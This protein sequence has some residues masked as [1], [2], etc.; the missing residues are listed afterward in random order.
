[1]TGTARRLL[2][3]VLMLAIVL[4]GAAQAAETINKNV[5]VLASYG[6]GRPGVE[7]FVRPYVE[8][9]VAGGVRQ[10]TLSVEY[11]NLNRNA[12]PEF[13]QRIHDLL[14]AQYKNE[15]IDLIVTLQQPAL[16]Y[17][18]GE[19]RELAA[20]IPIIAIDA[21][22]PAQPGQQA[23]MVTPR[24]L[25]VRGTLEQA[26][27]LYPDTERIIV[28]VG[29]GP[30]DQRAKQYVQGVLAEMN[31][32][33]VVEYMDSMSVDEMEQHV[34]AAPRR[35]IVLMS[36]VNR[37][38]RGTPVT[39]GVVQQRLAQL[40]AAPVFTLFSFGIGNGPMGGSVLH[41]ER[42]A[43]EVA[44]VTLDVLRGSRQ[45]APG[46]TVIPLPSTSMYDWKALKRWDGDWRL[47]P[48]DTVFVNRPESVLRDHK[49]VVV[50]SIAA[51]TLLSLLAVFLLVQRR[52]LLEAKAHF[53]VLVE[54][55][56]EAIVVYD[57]RLGRFVEANSQAEKLLAASRDQLLECGP[58]H[59]Y[60]PEQPDG[61]PAD[62]SIATNSERALAGEAM[63]FERIVR[64][65]DGR[66]FPCEVNLVALPS[67]GRPLLRASFVDISARK[68]AEQALASEHERLEQQVAER[69]AALQGAVQAA[70]QANRA[71]S[72]FLANMS[73]EL[74]TPLNSIIGF[75]QIMSEST[76]MFDDEKHNVAIINRS[77]HHLL[78]LINDIL[79]LSKIE[80]GQVQL[81]N[82][83][84]HL[85]EMLREIQDMMQVTAH[86]KGIA[87]VIDTPRLPP[88]VLLD[89][90]KLRQ[91][92]INL[93]SNAIK[94]TDKGS[95][96]LSL[97][98]APASES[99]LILQFAV[100]DTGIGI[101]PDQRERIF[102][103]FIQADTPKSR[104]GTG[105]G[106]TIS[107]EFVHL[108]GGSIALRSTPGEGSEFSFTVNA[109]IDTE[110]QDMP[111]AIVPLQEAAPPASVA[112]EWTAL[113][114]I[115]LE[116]RTA[117][118]AAL[119]ELDVRRVSSLLAT[120][121][122]RHAPLVAAIG[123]MLE[124]HQ[125]RELCALL[126]Q[127][128]GTGVQA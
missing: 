101:A 54:Y 52:K 40:S 118:R 123:A 87:L 83:T 98:M 90:G 9:V 103:P 4:P 38:A 72:R 57:V 41:V 64:A 33:L 31:R 111:E 36:P 67:R 44:K 117:L 39:A 128:F 30:A 16:D 15:R 58:E 24:D 96:T 95:V 19:L 115:A 61:V 60:V 79:E 124:K 49:D 76:S 94:F 105:L 18:L 114:V 127:G 23:L 22:P 70:E 99:T 97:R 78:S 42:T 63:G 110:A 106:L 104:A 108:L 86:G 46:V 116:T 14:A 8:A 25:H 112:L 91:V 7:S 48:A 74:R 69:T 81:V 37:D 68:L 120:L 65:M 6:Y 92:L 47:L 121:D 13:R 1:M 109:A 26:L 93:L 51:I 77:G 62:V 32:R 113:Q 107:R 119:Q 50:T 85:G 28:A 75:S 55:A 2:R 102:D 73:H 11:L 88:P 21:V 125:Y 53:R 43:S 10:E 89:G 56:P 27:K 59:F 29:A 3:A 80:A 35:S 66:V 45:P 122:A 71:K 100:R 34:A 126:E 82:E 84:V 17:A 20:G 12:G 5:L